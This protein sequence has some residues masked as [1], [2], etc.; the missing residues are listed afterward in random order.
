MP[1]FGSWKEE[2][3]YYLA[4]GFQI[5]QANCRQCGHKHTVIVFPTSHTGD[6]VNLDCDI[7]TAALLEIAQILIPAL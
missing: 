2:Q 6:Y 7:C 5:A 1:Q 3:A 4:E